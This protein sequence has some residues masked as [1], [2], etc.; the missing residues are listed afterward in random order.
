LT[1]PIPTCEPDLLYAGGTAKWTKLVAD[2]PST[3]GWTLTYSFRGPTA[4]ADV[5]A[6]ANGNGY[7]AT[8]TAVNSAPLTEGTYNW[9]AA[10]AKAGEVYIV[11]RGVFTV[12]AFTGAA[13]V[14]HEEKALAAI[15]GAIEGRVTSDM[16]SYTIGGRSVTKMDP[17]ELLKFKAIY[18]R[19]VWHLQNPGH[20]GIPVHVSFTPIDGVVG[21]PEPVSLPPWYRYGG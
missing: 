15:N 4:L 8:I 6:A 17:A 14:S 16:K 19:K 2:Y 12:V 10:V 3:D 1:P 20:I 11:A 7:L 5:V 9:T 21:T 13:V 18:E